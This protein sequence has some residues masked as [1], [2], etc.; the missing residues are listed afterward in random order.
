MV[1]VFFNKPLLR[2]LVGVIGLLAGLSAWQYIVLSAAKLGQAGVRDALAIVSFLLAGWLVM[3]IAEV[4]D[5][6]YARAFGVLCY[7][8]GSVI[9]FKWIF[10]VDGPKLADLPG[11]QARWA[12]TTWSFWGA[13]GLALAMLLILVVRLVLDKVNFGRATANDSVSLELPPQKPGTLSPSQEELLPPLTE[14]SM[15]AVPASGQV[16]GLPVVALKQT[17]GPGAPRSF[18]LEAGTLTI[19]RQD[20]AILL[21]DDNQVSRRHAVLESAAQGIAVLRDQGSTN[22]TWVNG[23]RITERQLSPGDVVQIGGSQFVAEG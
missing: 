20:S 3:V 8:L 2:V 19:G 10:L 13:T 17:L 6:H 23:V 11:A 7:L 1:F 9:S 12:M 4:A 18:N 5:H 16:L 21:A 15:L 22:G 14:N